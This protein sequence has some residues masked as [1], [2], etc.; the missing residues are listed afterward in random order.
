MQDDFVVIRLKVVSE[1]AR[2]A[3]EAGE[4]G[5]ARGSAVESPAVLVL[6]ISKEDPW[7]F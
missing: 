5:E 2:E 4:A 6:S 3:G 1:S 7:C